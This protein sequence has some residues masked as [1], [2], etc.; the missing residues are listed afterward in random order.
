MTL[1]QVVDRLRDEAAAARREEAIQVGRLTR[2]ERWLARWMGRRWGLRAAAGAYYESRAL[3][4]AA[5]RIERRARL[6][7]LQRTPKSFLR[8]LTQA[9]RV[10]SHSSQPASSMGPILPWP[11]KSGVC[12]CGFSKDS[13]SRP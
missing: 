12:T 9:T 13:V 1:R 8:P 6:E 3:E 10:L 11:R 7:A 4:A 2:W 5:A